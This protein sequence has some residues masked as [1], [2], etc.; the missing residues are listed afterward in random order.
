MCEYCKDIFDHTGDV[1]AEP[2]FRGKF[3]IGISGAKWDCMPEGF[4][5]ELYIDEN[6][7]ITLYSCFGENAAEWFKQ[8]I[9]FCPM[10][11]EQLVELDKKEDVPF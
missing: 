6:A 9:F 5:L 11:G 7:N 10:C 2:I 3:A 4:E 1:E 8:P